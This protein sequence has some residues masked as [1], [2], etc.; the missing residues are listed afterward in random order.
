MPVPQ[1]TIHTQQ[2]RVLKYLLLLF[3]TIITDQFTKLLAVKL[4]EVYNETTFSPNLFQFTLIKNYSGFLGIVNIFPDNIRFF[5]LNICVSF[6]LVGCLVYIFWSKNRPSCYSTP[7]VFVVGGGISNLV[8]RLLYDGGVIDFLSIGAG[9]FRTGIFNLADVYI[10][11]GSFVIGCSIF[12]SP[13][14]ST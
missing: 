9:S 13:V 7:L 10:L 14:E 3:F 5:L 8:D 4:F 6:L 2:R 12:S 1:L 11:A